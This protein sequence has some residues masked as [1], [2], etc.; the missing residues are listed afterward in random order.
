ML[1]LARF[2]LSGF[3]VYNPPPA[4]PTDTTE[5]KKT[6]FEAAELDQAFLD[7]MWQMGYEEMLVYLQALPEAER[8]AVEEAIN[9]AISHRVVKEHIEYLQG[10][11]VI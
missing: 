6:N 3:L 9:R 4:D 8:K 10:G 5:D 1:S 11:L 2:P 7:R